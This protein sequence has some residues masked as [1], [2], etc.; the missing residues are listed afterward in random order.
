[1]ANKIIDKNNINKESKSSQTAQDKGVG[2]TG[3]L[4]FDLFPIV[5]NSLSFNTNNINTRPISLPFPT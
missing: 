3:L 5:F 2:S 4:D 1:M